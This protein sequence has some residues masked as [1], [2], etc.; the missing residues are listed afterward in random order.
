MSGSLNM[1]GHTQP[2]NHVHGMPDKSRY[3]DIEHG[4]QQWLVD[5]LRYLSTRASTRIQ[6]QFK[7][8]SDGIRMY[9]QHTENV[10]EPAFAESREDSIT[11]GFHYEHINQLKL[12]IETYI[13]EYISQGFDFT[14]EVTNE[15]ASS[16]KEQLYTD[17]TLAKYLV[18]QAPDVA[19]IGV[20]V[21]S[22]HDVGTI[23]KQ[24]QAKYPEADGIELFNKGFRDINAVTAYRLLADFFDRSRMKEWIKQV[25]EYYKLTDTAIAAPYIDP[26]TY[27]VVNPL[28]DP[29]FFVYDVDCL[30]NHFTSQQ[31]AF[32]FEYLPTNEVLRRYPHLDRNDV[33]ALEGSNN[34][35]FG[36][37]VSRQDV[38][39]SYNDTTLVLVVHG[40]FVYTQ[41]YKEDE[42]NADENADTPP[43]GDDLDRHYKQGDSRNGLDVQLLEEHRDEPPQYQELYEMVAVG[44]EIIAE[45]GPAKNQ[46][47][48]ID[49]MAMAY[50]P[51]VVLRRGQNRGNAEPTAAYQIAAL[52]R[53]KSLLFHKINDMI[54]QMQG[55]VWGF[56]TSQLVGLG[57]EDPES[58]IKTAL[59][60][61][62]QN[63]MYFTNSAQT[64]QSDPYNRREAVEIKQSNLPPELQFFVQW[65]EKVEEE[66]NKLTSANDARLGRAGQ[67]QP[68][69]S[70]RSD[71]IQAS[72][73]TASA[74]EDFNNFMD[75]TFTRLAN[76]LRM[77]RV[78]KA[79]KANG[80]DE[81]LEELEAKM[82]ME[83]MR[84]GDMA[85]TYGSLSDFM[86]QDIGVH[87]KFTTSKKEKA[88]LLSEYAQVALQQGTITLEQYAEL[89][90]SDDI[91]EG[92]QKAKH[93]AAR[94]RIQQ[95]NR[96]FQKQQMQQ[97][98]SMMSQQAQLQ[99][100]QAIQAAR[101]A[102]ED[103]QRAGD[104][105]LERERMANE[106]QRRD[107]DRASEAAMR[108]ME[109]QD[110]VDEQAAARRQQGQQNQGPGT[111][112]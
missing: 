8:A 35:L 43:E 68:A 12:I 54:G 16:R 13:G 96:E 89:M 61:I 87:V 23:R 110:R 78:L 37:P 67:Y 6:Q 11:G 18:D 70:V 9:S 58:D 41:P 105:Q 75:R 33:E 77:S 20:Q 99:N 84:L 63:K 101:M 85:Y 2:L 42:E 27:D 86:L 90:D 14:V 51:P 92:L 39:S 76:L 24:L 44:G 83:N 28:I 53:I 25:Y 88:R 31:Y 60:M 1:G 30:D 32:H 80:E 15:A 48:S 56:D 3:K 47:R 102:Q 50:L 72:Y 69:S 74:V 55:N 94:Q 7:I 46:L 21:N 22:L 103:Q 109:Q 100:Q 98:A 62:K 59:R 10:P 65:Y 73:G 26:Q 40:W 64:Q 107:Q 4:E 91:E 57:G 106:N 36:Q 79:E 17:L 97:Q 66:I 81:G 5:V 82:Q 52:E 49:N 108:L 71:M 112:Q 38:V 19:S 104:A 93:M 34:T 45:G 29:R 111:N 95:E